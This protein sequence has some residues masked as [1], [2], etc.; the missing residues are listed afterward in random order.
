MTAQVQ[1]A[2]A[3]TIKFWDPRLDWDVTDCPDGPVSPIAGVPVGD[4]PFGVTN[5]WNDGPDAGAGVQLYAQP[6]FQ[7]AAV[8]V[9][10]GLVQLPCICVGPR[11]TCGG[12]AEAD[13]P[14]A[15]VDGALDPPAPVVVVDPP[16]EVVVVDAPDAVV[17][18]AE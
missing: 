16:E 7:P 10:V 15:V 13:D 5:T 1:L 4:F 11:S 17:V 2:D 12:P 3:C 6:M 18:V 9:K 8:V 14:D